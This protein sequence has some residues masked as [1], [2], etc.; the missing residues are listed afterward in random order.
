M[1]F[2][3]EKLK[4]IVEKYQITLVLLFGSHAKGDNR[5][6]SDVDLGILFAHEPPKLDALIAEL[7]SLFQ[8][9]TLDVV[10]LNHSDPLLRFEIISNYKILYQQDKDSF[11][12]FYL[13]TLKQYNDIQKLLKLEQTYLDNFVGG[14]RDGVHSCDPPQVN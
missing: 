4:A 11:I 12:N 14:A 13:N 8:D 3:E 7:I 9:K 2:N 1:L 6:D 10:V 5:P